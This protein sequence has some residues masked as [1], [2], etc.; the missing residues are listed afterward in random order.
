MQN[1]HQFDE[2]IFRFLSGENSTEQDKLVIEWINQSSANRAHFEKLQGAWVLVSVKEKIERIDVPAEW[3]LLQEKLLQKRLMQQEVMQQQLLQ[4]QPQVEQVSEEGLIKTFES[5][6]RSSLYRILRATA[7]AASVIG[8]LV[9]AYVYGG[10]DK[11]PAHDQV[12]SE[13][14]R[15]NVLASL[16]RHEENTSGKTK[17]LLLPDG[18]KVLLYHNSALEFQEPFINN[19]RELTLAGKAEFTVV[20]DSAKPFVVYADQLSTTVLGTRFSVASFKSSD[21]IIIQLFEGQVVV[22]STA[23]AKIKMKKAYYL[24]PGEELVYVKSKATAQLRKSTGRLSV[25]ADVIQQTPYDN[26]SI[27]ETGEGSWYMFNNQSLPQVFERL[28]V[29]YNVEISYSHADLR[30]LYFIGRFKDTDPLETI[31]KEIAEINDLKVIR[32]EGRFVIEK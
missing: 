23:A 11:R 3:I 13:E 9:L 19:M 12:K 14:P 22:Q 7:V 29:L 27:P 21:N 30:N 2:L 10:G 16:L 31:L 15:L 1:E 8:I 32:R 24:L 18:S 17:Q 26:P 25:P 4:Q 5:T 20:K 6:E 28:E